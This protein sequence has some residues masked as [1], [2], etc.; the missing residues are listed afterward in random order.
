EQLYKFLLEKK[1]STKIARAS[2]VSDVKIVEAPRYAGIDSPDKKKVANQFLSIGLLVSLFLITIRLFFYSR[3]RTVEH[4]KELTELPV[5]GMLPRVKDEENVG[6]VVDSAPSSQ[7][8]E[9]FRSFRTNLQ[10][11]SVD[12][13][14]KTYLV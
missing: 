14:A 10:Y 1:A 12:T 13:Q 9:A 11:A 7:I 2:I 8:A 5:I 4:L 6:V 3:I